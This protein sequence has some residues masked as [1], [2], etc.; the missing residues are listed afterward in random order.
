MDGLKSLAVQIDQASGNELATL[1]AEL[2]A[3][4]QLQ[5]SWFPHLSKAQQ[6]AICDGCLKVAAHN[7]K[8]GSA[9]L[10]RLHEDLLVRHASQAEHRIAAWT[11]WVLSHLFSAH[12][13]TPLL[14]RVACLPCKSL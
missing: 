12:N 3:G 7:L 1:L 2:E 11:T 5:R 6:A 4:A 13:V 8:H 9:E 14:P 10:Q